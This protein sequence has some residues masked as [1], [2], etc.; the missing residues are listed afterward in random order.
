MLKSLELKTHM[1]SFSL[2]FCASALMPGC[3]G[4]AA[5]SDLTGSLGAAPSVAVSAAPA[6]ADASSVVLTAAAEG[7]GSVPVPTPALGDDRPAH[8]FALDA[9]QQAE[10][11]HSETAVATSASVAASVPAT[12][13]LAAAPDAALGTDSTHTARVLSLSA[14]GVQ[15]LFGSG[16]AGVSADNCAPK[17]ASDFIDATFW[18]LRRLQPRDCD[19]VKTNPPAF[20]WTQPT[21][22]DL[23][24]PWQLV[25]RKA[26][27]GVVAT[28]ASNEP[29][30]ALSGGALAVG[31]YEWTVAYTSIGKLI[32]T[33]E[34][35]RFTVAAD[36]A[37][38]ALPSGAALAAAVS[39]KAHPRV[40]PAGSSFAAIAAVA[41][42]GEYKGA[43]GITTQRANAAKTLALPPPPESLASV[44]S[45]NTLLAQAMEERKNIESL[46]F[47]ARMRGDT[48]Y[49]SAGIARLMNLAAWSPTGASSEASQ[50]QINREIYLALA[51]GYDLFSADLTA[52]QRSL[53][54]ASLKARIGQAM[55]KFVIFDRYPYVSHLV[56][57][58][59]FT[60]EALLHVAGMPEFPESSAWLAKAW[61]AYLFAFN[62]WGYEDG[63]FG[64]GVAY[65][66]FNMQ[67][68][69]RTLAAIKII[70][71]VN[72]EKHPYMARYGDLQ[73]A[74]TAPAS[75]LMSPFGDSV[76]TLTLYS[77]LA[78]GDYRLYASVTRDPQHEWYWRAAPVNLSY[79]NYLSPWHYMMLGLS[80]TPA[81]PVAPAW[82]SWVSVDA[83]LAAMHSK[84][85][86]PLR[87][88]V[89]FRSSR[90]G[91]YNH[92]HADQNSFTLDSRGQNLLISAGYYPDYGSPHHTTVGRATRYKNA[93]TFDGGIGQA[94]TMIDATT[95]PT[96]PGKPI[97][98][99]DARGQLINFSDNKT[100]A[101]ATGD[102]ALA[103]RAQDTRQRLTPL[104]TNAV[105]SI[106]YQRAEKVVVIYDWATS[107]KPRKWEL[108]LHALNAFTTQGTG[109]RAQNAGSSGCI[110]VYGL[111]GSFALSDGFAVAPEVPRADEF[112]ARYSANVAS[113]QLTSITVIREDCRSVP[114]VVSVNGTLATVAINGATPI[115]FD[116]RT[117]R[118]P[119]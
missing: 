2:V 108:N 78:R 23:A 14:A 94:E 79:S 27:G 26:G 24:T 93:L 84:T 55:A 62:S 29:R 75:K 104:L 31:N 86:D 19:L 116:Q 85:S 105:R 51:Q 35:R 82:D 98:S 101:A 36:A 34:V 40:L 41:S 95:Q 52:D 49:Q 77:A 9:D 54:A 102:A 13:E 118:L 20:T 39:R 11:V 88:S 59:N 63:G 8:A 5:P 21:D 111:K 106:A 7:I 107:D 47:M 60:T 48:S 46:G 64:N 91:S 90:F 42:T 56:S 71:G 114:V 38:L 3:G 74:M 10:S 113:A 4:G 68:V 32:K 18:H 28:Q 97:Q 37:R 117:I 72:L 103:Y 69:G 17:L 66:W 25:L 44:P 115:A 30:L 6:G 96:T 100:W 57:A 89:Y 16:L 22:R 15:S 83:G 119:N 112:H 50:D 99:M 70:G 110:D 87:S 43:Y 33:S 1:L 80:P 92:S 67:Q 73:I 65:A 53:I 109:V 58:T 12:P 45:L 81:A 61:D 76:E